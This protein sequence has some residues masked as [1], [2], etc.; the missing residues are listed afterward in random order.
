MTA[1]V[2][3]IVATVAAVG[4]LFLARPA[5]TALEWSVRPQEWAPISPSLVIVTRDAASESRFGAETWDRTVLARVVTELSRAGAAAIGI[6]VALGQPGAPGRGGPAGDAL[7]SQATSLAGNVVYA[8]SPGEPIPA[9]AQHAR[10]VGHTAASVDADGVVRSVPL[11]MPIGEREVMAL[12][13]ALVATAREGALEKIP[14]DPS[15]RATF[16]FEPPMSSRLVPFSELWG[17]I[18]LGQRDRLQRLV[19]GKIVLLLLDPSPDV[20]RTPAGPLSDGAIQAQLA[21]AALTSSWRG[22]VPLASTVFGALLVA[23]V[24]A[25]MFL[26]LRWWQATAALLVVAAG[27][28]VALW[29]WAQRAGLVLPVFVP[30]VAAALAATVALTWKHA[31]AVRR[32]RRVEGDVHSIRQALVRQESAVE[33]L[34]EDLEAARAA[35]ARSTGTERELLGAVETLRTQLAVAQSQEETTRRTLRELEGDLRAGESTSSRMSDAERD[36]LVERCAGL[37]IVT[38]DPEMLRLFGDLERAA[39]S[40][41]PILIG[42]EPG[43][44]KELFARAAH[45]LSPR[46][47]GPFVA[48]NMAA[49]PP[50]LFESELFGHVKGSFTGAVSERRGYFEQADHGTLFLDEIGELRADHQGKLLRV[51][52]EKTFYKVGATRPVAVEVRIVAA[53]NRDLERGV[54]EGWFREDLY[55]RL[56]GLVLHL[57]PLRDRRHDIVPMASRFLEQIAAESGRSVKISDAALL[58]LQRHPWPGNVRELRHCLEQAVALASAAV[59]TPDDLRLTSKPGVGA[60]ASDDSAVLSSLRRNEFDMQATARALGWDRSTVT[61]R[62]KGLGFA[63]L[64]DAGGDRSRAALALAGDPRLARIV[65]LKLAEYHDHL[66]RAVEGFA[67]ADAAI[68]ACRRRFKNLPDRHFRSLESLVRLKFE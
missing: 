19:D 13:V 22:D 50:D 44:G 45:T 61:Q 15:G 16:L 41:L 25:W 7:L 11:T 37:G 34:E 2:I 65:E 3:G 26:A 24:V 47:D 8:M 17:A 40:S 54:A 52:Q 42:G 23:I 1:V 53:S 48:V 63:A 4:V 55:F 20:R 49:I 28:E 58:A 18:E 57:P 35:V 62:L 21:N 32:L 9:L 36:R 14:R 56:K 51:L 6:D 46:R 33:S 12:G 60:T 29:Q 31:V 59:L 27:Y 39:P 68:A 10:A 43:T 30:A 66:L 38:R 64:V 67:S 5:V